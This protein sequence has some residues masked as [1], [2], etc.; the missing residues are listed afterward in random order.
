[1][2][3]SQSEGMPV[4]LMEAAA[5]GV[6]AVAPSVGGI[7]ELIEDGETGFVTVPND[8]ASTAA[9]LATVLTDR[10]RRSR[11]GVAARARAVSRFSA[12][13]QV[14]TLLSLWSAVRGVPA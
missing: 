11:M 14:D 8:A 1:V 9:A 6:P 10:P 13:R 2:L 7:P 12:A 4:S 5:C 3:T